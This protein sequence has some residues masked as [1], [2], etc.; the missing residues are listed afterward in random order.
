ML[1]A[2]APYN[3]KAES[4]QN[5]NSDHI[6]VYQ[7]K[8]QEAYHRAS[9]NDHVEGTESVLFH[10]KLWSPKRRDR[11]GRHHHRAPKGSTTT[12]CRDST[13]AASLQRTITFIQ[14]DPELN[15]PDLSPDIDIDV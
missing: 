10:P 12:Q 8:I 15:S 13:M 7:L 11:P 3:S 14:Q 2:Y 1:L 4:C 9:M 5:E 6:F